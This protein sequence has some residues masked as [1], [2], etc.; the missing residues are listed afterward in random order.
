M[1]VQT[2]VLRFDNGKEFLNLK[3]QSYAS[4]QGI[5]LDTTTPNTPQ[6]NGV[7]ERGNTTLIQ[8]ARTQLKAS[9]VSTRYWTEGTQISCHQRN[10]M[11]YSA[12]KGQ[13]SSF[14]AML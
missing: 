6:Q 14:Q 8:M 10:R 12:F 7:A 3:L 13:M 2:Q 1:N 9:T 5:R 11:P 4:S